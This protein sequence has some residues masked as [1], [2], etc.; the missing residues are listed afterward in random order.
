MPTPVAGFRDLDRAIA[1]HLAGERVDLHV[2]RN[3][4][5]KVVS[6]RLLRRTASFAT[7]S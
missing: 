1:A 4:H 6:V 7:C 3:G 2:V 5:R